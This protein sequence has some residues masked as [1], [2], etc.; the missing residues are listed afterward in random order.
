MPVQVL[1]LTQ[2]EQALEERLESVC[3]E[4]AELRA[5]LASL[6]ARLAMRDQLNQQHNQRVGAHS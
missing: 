4:N 5:N 6:N 2:R 3:Q 1:R